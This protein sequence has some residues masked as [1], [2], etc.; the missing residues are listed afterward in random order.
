[1]AVR[2][3][4]STPANPALP[5]PRW[6]LPILGDLLTINPAKPT[7]TSMRDAR[8]LGSIFERRIVDWPMIVLSGADLIAEINDERACIGV[9]FKKVRPVARDG[10]FTAYH[11]EPN[12]TKAHNIL[13]PAFTREATTTMT[14]S[15][16]ELLDHWST[17]GDRWVD[18]AEDMNELSLE[19]I[20]R[21][22]FDYTFDSFTRATV[23]PSSQ[24]CCADSPTSTATPTCPHCCRKPWPPRRRPVH[25]R[26]RLRPSGRRRHHRRPADQRNPRRT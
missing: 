16:G 6:R 2:T 22:G 15:I 25:P 19:I 13:A 3:T 14:R 4:T 23:A 20:S 8:T 9:L 18:V 24:P 17:R 12:W 21:A 26:H 11:H 10:L 5:H 7:Q 1:M